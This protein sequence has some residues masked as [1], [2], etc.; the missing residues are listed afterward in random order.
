MNLSPKEIK[1]LCV[2]GT[3]GDGAGLYLQVTP[4]GTKSWIYRYQIDGR[5]RWLGLG[6]FPAVSLSE[7]RKERSRLKLK[8]K[9]GIDPLNEKAENIAKAEVARKVQ[10][11]RKMTFQNC[12]EAY[13]ES[14]APHWKN[15]KHEQQWRN[16]LATYA[17]PAIGSLAVADVDLDHVLQIL[18]PIWLKKTETATRVRNRVELV[19]DWANVLK[20]GNGA[21]PARWKGNLDKI[22]PKPSKLK[23]NKHHA[24]LRYDDMPTFMD[25]LMRQR[26]LGA[27]ALELTILTASRTSE[28]LNANW[29]EFDLKKAMWIIP[30]DRMKAGKEHRI[31]L[32]P[33]A[34]KLLEGLRSDSGSEGHVFP[35]QKRGKSLSNMAMTKVLHR[36]GRKD[37]TVHGFR[38]T[39][40][41][42]IAE[43]TSFPQRVAETALA[44]RLKDGAEAAYQRG[45]LFDKRRDLMAVWAE[46]CLTP[47]TPENLNNNEADSND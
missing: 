6:G 44:H 15:R 23:G 12:A 14:M 20:Y 10:V 19:I 3:Y 22:L 42:W 33:A 46:Y 9:A 36:M 30:S 38:S 25:A 29:D 39:F 24:A 16:T 17:Y 18:Q 31:P 2:S 35:G 28:V 41:D 34:I 47:S 37:I 32:S 27:R 43:Q 40:R 26:G 8:V 5:R 4:N 13:I 1:E 11:A 45:D 21:N 7:A